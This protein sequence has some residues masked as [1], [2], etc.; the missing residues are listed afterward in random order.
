MVCVWCPTTCCCR[1]RNEDTPICTHTMRLFL[2]CAV[3]A[4]SRCSQPRCARCCRHTMRLPQSAFAPAPS[5]DCTVTA[6]SRCS[7]PRMRKVQ[8]G[9]LTRPCKPLPAGRSESATPSHSAGRSCTGK[10]QERQA[11]PNW[12]SHQVHCCAQRIAC[13]PV[14]KPSAMVEVMHDGHPGL[15]HAHAQHACTQRRHLRRQWPCVTTAI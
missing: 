4:S 10:D 3:T 5:L 9:R 2:N 12:R 13:A 6:S 14:G 15:S 7:Q 8:R 11:D 1:H